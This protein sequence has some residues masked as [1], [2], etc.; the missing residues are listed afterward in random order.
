M[1][2]KASLQLPSLFA[3]TSIMNATPCC[4]CEFRLQFP[5]LET[6]LFIYTTAFV[7]S[8]MPDPKFTSP[9]FGPLRRL[10]RLLAGWMIYGH[11]ISGLAPF[12]HIPVNKNFWVAAT[13]GFGQE[14]RSYEMCWR[15]KHVLSPCKKHSLLPGCWGCLCPW[16]ASSITVSS[17]NPLCCKKRTTLRLR[18]NKMWLGNQF[19][20]PELEDAM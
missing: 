1:V 10:P 3:N 19:E 11:A 13:G 4:K 15:T 6:I 9:N 20:I 18:N 2:A 16:K 17:S 5:L 8:I 12:R 14:G 7:P